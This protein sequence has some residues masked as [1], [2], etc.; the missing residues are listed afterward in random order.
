MG[1][2]RKSRT[3][4]LGIN[5]D[6]NIEERLLLFGFVNPKKVLRI[7]R[8]NHIL[9]K[10]RRNKKKYINDAEPVVAPYQLERQFNTSAPNKKWFTEMP[11]L[12]FGELTL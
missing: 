11:Y 7:M 4:V 10:G 9:S 1:Q 6:M 12:V 2:K 5:Y 3:S 8:Q